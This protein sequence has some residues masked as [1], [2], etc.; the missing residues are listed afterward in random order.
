MSDHDDEVTTDVD[1]DWIAAIRAEVAAGSDPLPDPTARSG[2]G[3]ADDDGV[4]WREQEPNWDDEATIGVS[5]GILDRI[6]S[7]IAAST[8]DAPPRPT[9]APAPASPTSAPAP[10]ERVAQPSALADP[11]PPTTPTL[12][13]SPEHD[14]V[15]STTVRWE[16]RQRLTASAPIKDESAV[17]DPTHH[18]GMDRTKTAIALIAAATVILVVWLF[19]RDSG[20]DAPPPGSTPTVSVEGGSVPGLTVAP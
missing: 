20:S 13:P 2:S 9:T 14:A 8:S 7:E 6:R 17:T 1:P 11:P 12:T 10:P 4:D 15:V 18:V 5:S 16:P 19:V 3:L